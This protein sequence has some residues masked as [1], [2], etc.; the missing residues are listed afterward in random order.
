MA[1]MTT[2]TVHC[3]CTT[4]T[5]IDDRGL[6]ARVSDAWVAR[7]AGTSGRLGAQATHSACWIAHHPQLALSTQV[8]EHGPWAA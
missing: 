3:N 8:R 6:S 7:L 1:G 4:C 2:V 5:T